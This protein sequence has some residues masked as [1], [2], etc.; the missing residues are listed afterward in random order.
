MNKL[1]IDELATF[2]KKKGFIIKSG[3]IYGGFQGFFDYLFLGAELK[4]NLKD[5]WWNFHVRAR[6]DIEGIDGAIITN[7]EV[8]KASGHVDSFS[9]VLITCKKCKKA[10]KVDKN[11]IGKV[12][13]PSCGGE[14]DWDNVKDIEQMFKTNVGLDSFG[15]LRPET[16]QLIFANFKS[17]FEGAR[18]KLP[19][20]IAQMGKSFRNEI[21]PRNFLF[22]CREFEQ[23]EIEYFIK[24]GDK[25]PFEIPDV[26]IL[27]LASEDNK[28]KLMTLV[29]AHKKKIIKKDWHAY[30]LGQALVWFES[31]GADLKNFRIRQHDK[32]ELAHYSTDC[33][34]LEYNFPFG[35][36]ELQGIADR[37]NYDL[38]Q[39]EKFSKTKMAVL[40]EETKEKFI[41][42]VVCEPSF[43]VERA[44]L[45]FL[46][47]A[48]SVNEKGNVVLKLNPKLAPV[49]AAIFPLMKKGK[50][51]EIA[52][53]IFDDLKKKFNV[54]YDV[55]G[56]VGRRYARND[57]IGTPFC[58]TVDD[59]SISGGTVTIRDRDTTEQ[60]RVKISELRNVLGDLI[61]GEKGF[62]DL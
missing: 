55:S 48:Y 21:A 15:Y 9:D 23:M 10:D 59:D 36:K 19:C 54:N 39:H 3:E 26:K 50:Q 32:D 2:C 42:E 62:K 52:R 12:K 7:P 1:S 11:E 8:W 5:S 33:W 17:V 58:I 40:D 56:S 35:W 47:E 53:G 46:Y 28:G 14:I 60:K 13:C 20:G 44:L 6:E 16:A 43:G 24:P 41:P 25:C 22:R 37:G 49:K 51:A 61:E 31:L 4:R 27:V 45:V 18:M 57:E 38:T 34:D 30:W 29:E